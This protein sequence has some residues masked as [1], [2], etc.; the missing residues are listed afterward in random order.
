MVGCLCASQL[1]AALAVGEQPAVFPMVVTD[2]GELK[3]IPAGI[4][5]LSSD[6]MASPVL[7]FRG[8]SGV[9]VDLS[10]LVLEGSAKDATP[11]QREGLAVLIEDCENLTISG[12]KARGYKV[13]ILARNS[14]GLTITRC[15][16]SGN[17]AP[18]L[19]S[20]PEAENDRD[21]LS[22]HNNEKDEWLRYGAAI[23]LDDCA[24]PTITW[25]TA[26]GGQNGLLM[27]GVRHG[28]VHSNS[29]HFLSGVGVGLY[30]SSFNAVMHNRLDFCVRGYS[31]GVYQRGQDSAAILVYEQSGHNLFAYNS[32]THSGDGFFLW[33][34]QSTMDSGQGGCND[35]LIYGNDFS[36]APTNGIE[37]TFSRNYFVANQIDDCDYGVWGGY[38]F[39]S[40]FFANTLSANRVGVAIEHGQNNQIV[41]NHFSSNGTAIRLWAREKQPEDWGYAKERDTRSRDA[42]VAGN[43]FAGNADLVLQRSL[44]VKLG[45]DARVRSDKES[46]VGAVESGWTPPNLADWTPPQISGALDPFL[47][48]SFPR[49]RRSIL[50]TPYGPYDFRTPYLN[51]MNRTAD[52]LTF[53]VLGPKGGWKL[54]SIIGATAEQKSGPIPGQLR[55]KLPKTASQVSLK[56]TA[57][58]TPL[59]YSMLHLPLDYSV[60]FYTYA[61]TTDLTKGELPFLNAIAAAPVARERRA[62]LNYSAVPPNPEVPASYYITVAETALPVPPGRYVLKVTADDGIRVYLDT[63]KIIDEW[64]HQ[65]PTTFTQTLELTGYQALRIEHFQIT[66]AARLQVT[67][68]PAP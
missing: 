21:W 10:R 67:L 11:D 18:K 39:D 60:R 4:Q 43:T 51:L 1:L 35:N 37:A 61:P 65:T 59:T 16:F 25:N 55:V 26:T 53:E 66:G 13:A 48:R 15:D 7:T 58:D 45:D 56:L 19:Y 29:F 12:L 27:S 33:A 40:L 38:S 63:K 2:A 17:Y 54:A 31:H 52:S 30:R 46:T 3:Q 57:G 42:I 32:A 8:L 22:Y 20:T 41:G 49:G 50:M 34:G 5:R 68:T 36:H 14:P 6:S 47:P 23:Y 28:L 44:G 62:E 64:R 9:T 24:Y